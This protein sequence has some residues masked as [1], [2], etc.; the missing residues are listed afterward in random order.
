M[1]SRAVLLGVGVCCVLFGSSCAPIPK[2]VRPALRGPQPRNAFVAPG[3]NSADMIV[4]NSPTFNTPLPPADLASHSLAK[5][6]GPL[7]KL[8][9]EWE[10]VSDAQMHFIHGRTAASEFSGA[11]FWGT[12]RYRDWNTL[13]VVDQSYDLFLGPANSFTLGGWDDDALAQ[14]LV[15]QNPDLESLIEL[16]WDSGYFAPEAAPGAGDETLAVGRWA[17]DCGHEAISKTAPANSLGFR[18][19]I[20]APEIVLSSHVVKSDATAV[21]AQFRLFA[22]S[23]S[24]PLDT[25]PALFFLQRLFVSRRNPLGGQ[26]YSVTLRPPSD[27]WKINS[28]SI[29]EGSHSGGRPHRIKGLV[30]SEDGGK[31]LNLLLSARTLKPRTKIESSALIDVNWVPADSPSGGATKCE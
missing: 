14:D 12:H 20:H 15:L 10:D 19:E 24:G 4:W 3:T 25:A 2:R 30:Q 1:S 28:C 17:F 11:D 9:K 6:G 27:G 16:E 31:T 18:T 22:G 23:R 26:D 21:Q 13:L 5:C 29:R 8:F 7:G